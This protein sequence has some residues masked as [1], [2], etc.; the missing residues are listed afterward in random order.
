MLGILSYIIFG[1]ILLAIAIF[2][3][4]VVASVLSFFCF[5]VGI[6]VLLMGNITLG[7]IMIGIGAALGLL[8]TKR[9]PKK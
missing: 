2:L 5:I 7:V 9:K 8:A 1:L 3:V 6:V 4:K